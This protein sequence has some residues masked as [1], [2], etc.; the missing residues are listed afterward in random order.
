MP[1]LAPPKFSWQDL[2]CTEYNG[3][4]AFTIFV[5]ACETDPTK[6]SLP[7]LGVT[8][9]FSPA[10]VKGVERVA[11]ALQG[12]TLK[13]HSASGTGRVFTYG[14]VLTETERKTPFYVEEETRQQFW[15]TVLQKL[16]F[17]KDSST[18]AVT[19]HAKF[20][21]GNTYPTTVRI[22]HYIS[23]QKW[24]K[25]RFTRSFPLTDTVKW[26]IPGNSGSFPECLH[27]VCRFDTRQSSEST[28]FGQ[29]TTATEIGG[30]SVVQEFPATTMED[31][32]RYEAEIQ[33]NKV[34]GFWHYVV[35]EFLPPIDDREATT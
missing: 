1:S 3:L 7:K 18:G 24:P 34:M 31:W 32:G 27:P 12:Y 23:D 33:A 25:S 13:A 8:W 2:P 21:V 30:D 4:R 15:P 26:S 14:P 19:D 11:T 16:W 9:D 6:A 10:W 35:T 5:D 29:G 28:L 22:K 20:R 17:T